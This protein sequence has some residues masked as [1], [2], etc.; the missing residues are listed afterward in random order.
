MYN[1]T[2]GFGDND[3]K[4]ICGK[5]SFFILEYKPTLLKPLLVDFE[6]M[7]FIRRIRYFLEFLGKEHYTVYYLAYQGEL[8]GHCV[9]AP[10]GRRLKCSNIDDIV[11][12]PLYISETFRG[13]GFASSFLKLLIE[14]L[15][16]NNAYAWVEK[17]NTA[18]VKA[19]ESAGFKSLNIELNVSRFLRRLVIV[20]QGKDYVFKYSKNIG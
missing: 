16:F 11:I 8:I 10:G 14:Q 13:K 12:G 15:S 17:N 6:R 1:K 2:S 3:M 7:R 9:V 19:F 4:Y 5:D 20:N 18:S